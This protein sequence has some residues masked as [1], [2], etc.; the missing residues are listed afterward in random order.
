MKGVPPGMNVEGSM[1]NQEL[2]RLRE[3]ASRVY[4][5]LLVAQDRYGL[6]IA[7]AQAAHLR[8]KILE[9]K[10][11]DLEVRIKVEHTRRQHGE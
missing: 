6:L 1:D 11:K 7:Q 9:E 10:W 4:Q 3:E 8:Y 2:E 5:D